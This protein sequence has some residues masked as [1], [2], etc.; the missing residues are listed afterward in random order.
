MGLG[1]YVLGSTLVSAIGSYYCSYK[2]SEWIEDNVVLILHDKF[3]AR[4]LNYW[5]DLQNA[6]VTL[7][8]AIPYGYM[9]FTTQ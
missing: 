9:L 6:F 7:T 2:R 5:T 8:L 3:R 4:R 1:Y